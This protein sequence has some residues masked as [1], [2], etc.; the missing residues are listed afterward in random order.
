MYWLTNAA[1]IFMVDP[2][3][4]RSLPANIYMEGRKIVSI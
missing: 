1:I 3:R 4:L 2:L